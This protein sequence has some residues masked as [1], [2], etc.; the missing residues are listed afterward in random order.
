VPVFLS[1]PSHD[2]DFTY[3]EDVCK[4][5]GKGLKK[6]DLVIL[7][8]TVPVGTTENK[9]APW[10][11]KFSGLKNTDFL[12]AFS[13]ER[14]MT[15]FALSRYKNFPKVVGGA[16]SEA[17]ERAYQIYSKFCTDVHK[18]SN[19]RTAELIKISEG[20]YRNI[21]I[22]IANELY[23]VA[24]ESNI[25]FWE[26]RQ[27]ARHEYCN[28]MEPGAV[29]GHCTP[30]YPWFLI[31]SFDV[32]LVK[33]AVEVNEGMVDFLVGE[34]KRRNVRKVGVV[35]MSWREGV[36]ELKFS[37]AVVLIERL[38]KEK[39]DVYVFDKKFSSDE[40][41]QLGAKPLSNFKEMDVVITMN[42][43][44]EVSGELCEISSKVIDLK[45]VLKRFD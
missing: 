33:S 21:N 2:A 39:F 23:K 27:F 25:D 11:A 5:I 10:L 44:P 41:K 8:T 9:V 15:G 12:V 36:N 26:V 4:T 32:P 37:R 38:V 45:N 20:V 19:A 34:V 16:T 17:T 43:T 3:L 28:I 35:G 13:P 31:K 22:A 24:Q 30:V 40:I 1:E 14:I 18:V 42:K 6:G 7:E 29:G